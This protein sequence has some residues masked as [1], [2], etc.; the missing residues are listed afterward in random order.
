MVDVVIRR[1]G[2]ADEQAFFA[3]LEGE[4]DDWREYVGPAGRPAYA[5]A[6]RSS[7]AYLLLVD[8]ELCGYA[9]CRD[10][11]GFGV[12]V[13]DLLVRGPHRGRHLGRALMERVCADAPGQTVY[14]MSDVDPYY[15]KLGYARAG[16]IFVVT[17]GA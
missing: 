8:G 5:R 13:H 4:G 17:P 10:D 1:Y 12:Y 11:D 14:V 9:R 2:P 15:E 6:M 16:S 3:M 7:I